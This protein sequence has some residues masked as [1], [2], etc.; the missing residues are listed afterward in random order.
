MIKLFGKVNM[1][2]RGGARLDRN[3]PLA[4]STPAHTYM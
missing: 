2:L 4:I 3:E 1:N